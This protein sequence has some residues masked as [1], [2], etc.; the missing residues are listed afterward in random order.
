MEKGK[1]MYLVLPI[2]YEHYTISVYPF[3]RCR[4]TVYTVHFYVRS[5]FNLNY[6]TC[7]LTCSVQ[8]CFPIQT[9]NIRRLRISNNWVK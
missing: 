6:K 5:Q 7:S 1:I 8:Q 2:Y 4:V 3:D 9:V